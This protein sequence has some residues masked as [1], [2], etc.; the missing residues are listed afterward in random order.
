MTKDRIEFNEAYGEWHVI[1]GDTDELLAAC[2]THKEA[3]EHVETY[4][5]AVARDERQTTVFTNAELAH[6]KAAL[7]IMR[8]IDAANSQ[9]EGDECD[10][11]ATLSAELIH[12]LEDAGIYMADGS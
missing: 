10:Q 2:D 7:I 4:A 11:N 5:N 3:L 8:D 6:I 9:R 1:S 12:R